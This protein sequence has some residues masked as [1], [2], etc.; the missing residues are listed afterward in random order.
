MHL[1]ITATF[2]FLH[3][4]MKV[5]IIGGGLGGLTLAHGLKKAGIP[6]Q[7]FEEQVNF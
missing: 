4:I 5:L 7:V 3:G 2:H 1:I 6:V